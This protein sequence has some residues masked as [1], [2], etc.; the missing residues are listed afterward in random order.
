MCVTDIGTQWKYKLEVMKLFPL[1]LSHITL[2]Y[3]NEQGNTLLY[4]G[5]YI[6]IIR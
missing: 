4:V 5:Y 3:R 6:I 1:M 2:L